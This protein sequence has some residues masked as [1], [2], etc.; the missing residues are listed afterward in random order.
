[1]TNNTTLELDEEARKGILPFLCFKGGVFKE[2]SER[3]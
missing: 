2:K 3:T 1:M